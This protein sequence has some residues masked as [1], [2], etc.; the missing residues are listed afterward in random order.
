VP[1]HAPKIPNK[2]GWKE[3]EI[4]NKFSYRDFSRFETELELKFRE[5]L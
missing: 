4:R 3:N 5:L 2:L 1:S